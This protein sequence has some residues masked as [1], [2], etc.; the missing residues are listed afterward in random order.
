MPS[1]K[2]CFE[3]T[4]VSVEPPVPFDQA[5]RG[6]RDW[7]GLVALDSS[8]G[9]PARHSWI[10][11]DPIES[12]EGWRG[13]QDLRAAL[14]RWRTEAAIP[15]PFHGGFLGALGYELGVAGESL[16][17]PPEPW[18]WPNLLGGLYT[19]FLVFDHQQGTLHLVVRGGSDRVESVLAALRQ[20]G[21][22]QPIAVGALQRHTPAATHMERI[23]VAR[24][25]IAAGEYYQ[26]N[27]AHRFS[28]P[29]QGD[30]LDLYLRLRSANPAPYAGF[31]RGSCGACLSSSP[32]LLLEFDGTSARTRPIKGTAPRYADPVADL[33]ARDALWNSPK[34][35]A[36][37]AMI[38]DL[39][40]NDLGRIAQAGTVRVQQFP[41]LESYARVHHLV[42]TVS[43]TPRPGVDAVDLLQALFPGG[44][45]T[46]AP[47]LA[48][49]EAIARLEQEGRGLFTGSLGF[50][51]FRGHAHFNIL[52]RTV[53]WRPLG[54]GQGEISFRVGG[55]ITW[56]SDPAAEDQ[57]TLHK[58]HGMVDAWGAGDLS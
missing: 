47:K 18:G 6:L 3:P 16:D 27:L 28:A 22:A 58:A 9:H 19:D 21:P 50:V 2:Q 49:M 33:A 17:L 46:G 54:V 14:D 12:A 24:K 8:G 51:D 43:A 1:P 35:R 30:P 41:E 40:R 42:A 11:F 32:E 20:P 5:L 45:I 56:A 44:S 10:A 15:G 7:R 29:M 52:I 31:L 39:E 53:L 34:D 26:V 36:E 23:E 37:L 57:E 4:I 13:W 38:V 25:D 55:G 48:S